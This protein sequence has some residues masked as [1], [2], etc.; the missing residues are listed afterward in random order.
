MDGEPLKPNGIAL[1]K[2]GSFLLAHLGAETGGVFR[3]S[4]DGHTQPFL[5]TV[6]GLELPPTNYVVEDASGRTWITISTRLTPRAM[7]YRRSC[8][9]GCCANSA[10]KNKTIQSLRMSGS[11]VD[12][13]AVFG[14]GPKSAGGEGDDPAG[15]HFR[16]SWIHCAVGDST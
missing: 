9:D 8:N 15:E 11:L 5:R 12:Y 4:R 6:D 16:I 7:G 13:F 10:G 14:R 2:D 1:L 3:L